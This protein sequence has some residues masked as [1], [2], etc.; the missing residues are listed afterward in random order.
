MT[1]LE[2]DSFFNSFLKKEDFSSDISLNGI[3]IQN[4]EPAK[5]Q[6]KKI[7]FAV[8]ACEATAKA[9]AEAGA[10][11]LFVHHGLFWGGC[12][13]ITGSFYKRISTFIKNDLALCAYH[14]P[15]DAN[16]PYGNNFGLAARLGL[17]NLKAFGT[18]RGMILGA[19][20]ELPQELTTEE[21]ARK[22]LRPGKKPNCII[23]TGKEKNKTVGI[24]SGGASED[25]EAAVELGLDC[26]ITGE[27]AHED[28]HF[29]E[30]MG[31]NVIGGGHYE[32]ETVGVS[33]VME[34][35]QKELGIECVFIDLPTG[36]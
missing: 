31:I 33:L 3:Q 8:D 7:A 19:Y 36:L 24:I 11:V 9:A 6:I 29:A 1:L 5:K 18:W 15:L 28:Y 2:L 35:V 4:E 14:I 17:T 27:F 22:V 30:E 20:G 23:N 25:V 32:T 12:Q 26:Y 10:D 16:N 21:I 34:K 13:T